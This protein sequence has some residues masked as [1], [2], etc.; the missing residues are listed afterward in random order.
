MNRMQTM[1]GGFRP[2]GAG[3]SI[4][5]PAFTYARAGDNLMLHRA[6]DLAAP[7]DII[8]GDGGQTTSPSR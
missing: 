6:C 1:R 8:V 7:G 5:G 2:F 4:A 3:R